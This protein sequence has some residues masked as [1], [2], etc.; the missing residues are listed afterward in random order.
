MQRKQG[1][2][3]ASPQPAGK[4]A[5]MSTSAADLSMASWPNDGPRLIS[6]TSSVSLPAL[7]SSNHHDGANTAHMPRYRLRPLLILMAVG[8]PVLAGAWWLDGGG[9]R[10]PGIVLA[11]LISLA[12]TGLLSVVAYWRASNAKRS[13][14]LWVALPWAFAHLSA[15][16]VC[17]VYVLVA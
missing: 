10:E 12:V 13:G 7:S 9:E 15:F 3:S 8:P 14:I 6:K 16:L 11:N 1:K 17:V 4:F 5:S 2:S